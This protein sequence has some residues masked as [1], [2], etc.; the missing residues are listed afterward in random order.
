[1]AVYRKFWM[2]WI[3][4]GP[5]PTFKHDSREGANREAERLALAMPSATYHVLEAVAACKK[6]TV[7]WSEAEEDYQGSDVPF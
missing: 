2:V 5:A 7:Q 3:E 4:G 6:S 1:M